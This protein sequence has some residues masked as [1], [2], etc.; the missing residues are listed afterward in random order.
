L[1]AIHSKNPE[2]IPAEHIKQHNLVLQLLTTFSFY[3]ELRSKYA[4]TGLANVFL[5]YLTTKCIDDVRAT[6]MVL[7][8]LKNLAEDNDNQTE[9]AWYGIKESLEPMLKND[10]IAGVVKEILLLLG[11]DSTPKTPRKIGRRLTERDEQTKKAEEPKKVETKTSA[12]PKEEPKPIPKEEPKVV[13]KTQRRTQTNCQA[14]RRAQ[15]NS[16]TKRRT[17]TNGQTQRR[18][19]TN[20]Q[21]KRRT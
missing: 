14:K 2:N 18:A 19:K 1:I 6:D 11:W 9:L 7:K 4:Y 10:K 17:Q 5:N 21:T 13:V 16:Q 8:L 3:E 15:T 20:C 12:K